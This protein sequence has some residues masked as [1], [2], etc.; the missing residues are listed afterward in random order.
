MY[1]NPITIAVDDVPVR[2]RSQHDLG[3]LRDIGT[4]FC[5]FDEQDSGNLCFGLD[6]GSE[7]LF[8]KYAGAPTIDYDGRPGDAV[9]RLREAM[10]AYEDLRHP[11]LVELREHFPVGQGYLAIFSWFPGRCLHEHWAF[12]PQEKFTHPDSPSCRHKQLSVERRLDCLDDIFEFH[13]FVASRGYV[14][15]DFY[16]GS[17]LYDFSRH[18]TK[19][20]DID[21][22][23]PA[24]YVNNMGRL[25]GS[26]RFMAPEEF[27]RGAV[28]DEIT[29]VFVMGATAFAILGGET[30]RTVEKWDAGLALYEVARKAVSPER[31]ERYPTI[32]TLREAWNSARDRT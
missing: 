23:Q 24:P 7:R 28:I 22:Y 19:V 20:C 4:A 31:G 5:V 29:N 27:E 12:T 21:F 17:I 16:D 2:L 30:D 14:A 13:E 10:P 11:H 32:T 6:A 1:P 25:W 18:A 15:I 8:V 3:F 26:T 9:R